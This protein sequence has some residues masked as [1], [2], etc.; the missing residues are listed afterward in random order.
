MES[1]ISVTLFLDAYPD[2]QIQNNHY[3]GKAGES[4]LSEELATSLTI[5]WRP[6]NYCWKR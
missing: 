1:F 4:S 2:E 5:K 6:L 3:T